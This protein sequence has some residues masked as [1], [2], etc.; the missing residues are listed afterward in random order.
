MISMKDFYEI[1]LPMRAAISKKVY[2]IVD[3]LNLA[4]RDAVVEEWDIDGDDITYTFYYVWDKN[5]TYEMKV[6][7]EALFEESEDEIVRLYKSRVNK[8]E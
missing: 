2:R 1:Y 3:I 7:I 4:D 5:T 8:T 6:P